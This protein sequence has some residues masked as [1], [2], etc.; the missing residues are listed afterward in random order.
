MSEDEILYS[1]P[2]QLLVV[3]FS[4]IAC[5]VV[6]GYLDAFERMYRFSRAYQGIYFD[7]ISVFLP[8]F[9]AMGFV[10]YAYRKI[11]D[12]EIE[13]GKRKQVEKKL[14]ESERLFQELSITD[15]LTKLFNARHFS[16]RL[17]GEIDR[18]IRYDSKLSLLLID[19]DNF[20]QFNDTFGHL[21]GDTIL[22]RLGEIIMKALRRTDSAY[23][24]GGEE[25]AVILPE[26]LEEDAARVAERMRTDFATEMLRLGRGGR[27]ACTIS[28]GATQ[29]G[30]KEDAEA[31]LRRV[32]KAMYEAKRRGKNQVCVLPVKA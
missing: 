27:A 29:Y 11:Q 5:T 4:A 8:S 28:I 20:K 1:S 16:D 14:L 22:T 26:T 24:Y 21:E 17:A 19:V 13:I 3:V 9:L 7:E 2:K 15:Y 25:F 32:D 23:R 30:P 6:M 10:I 18:V 12:L 31:V